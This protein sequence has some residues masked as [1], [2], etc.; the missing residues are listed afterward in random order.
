MRRQLLLGFAVLAA[1]CNSSDD[2]FA[3]DDAPGS[4]GKVSSSG[5]DPAETSGSAASSD[6]TSQAGTTGSSSDE[7]GSTDI[8]PD[9]DTEG[10]ETTD[11]EP[12]S[13]DADFAQRCNA[14]GVLVCR[15]FDDGS[16]LEEICCEWETGAE[17]NGNGSMDFITVDAEQYTSGSGALRFQIDGQTGANHSGAFRQL[18]G[19]SFGPGTDLYVQ[20]RLRVSPEFFDLPGSP[21]FSIFHHQSATCNDVEWTLVM[22]DWYDNIPTMYTHCGDRSPG[23]PA[24]GTQNFQEGD[25]LCPYGSDFANDPSCLKYSADRWMTFY[26]HVAVGDWGSPTS[27][28]EAWYAVDGQPYEQWIDDATYTLDGSGESAPGFDSVYL[29]T[30]ITGKDSSIDHETAYAWYDELIISS[31]PIA[32]PTSQDTPGQD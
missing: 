28:L 17:A 25:Y 2:T 14:D 18:V 19:E 9:T 23:G 10:S 29:T 22:N 6:A 4:S 20:Y 5:A 24:D 31:Q 8:T 13:G 21:K 1:A 27:H 26:F 11:L 32:A 3:G 12:L 15:G 16:E 30:Y 7:G